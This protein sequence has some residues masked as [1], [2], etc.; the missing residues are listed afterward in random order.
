MEKDWVGGLLLPVGLWLLLSA[1]M[2]S[3]LYHR[4]ASATLIAS[5]I[6]TLAF[7]VFGFALAFGGEELSLSIGAPPE[8]W[9]FAG[10]S[11]F[12]LDGATNLE[13]LR[14]FVRFWPLIATGAMLVARVLGQQ[15]RIVT[16][17]VFTIVVTGIILPL[18][19]CW[20]WGRGW[21]H[22]LGTHVGLG[23][24]TVDLGHLAT[25]GI[26][27]G[28]FGVVW[29]H[30]LPRRESARRESHLPAAH[31][32]VRAVAGAL[33]V[34]VS[35]PAFADAFAPEAP[36]LPMGQFVSSSV[37]ASIAILTAGGYT[38][39][40]MRR[41]DVLSASRAAV[42]AVLATSSGGALLPMPVIAALGIICGLLATIGYY[43]VNERLRWQDDSA[44][45][46][47]VFV[48]AAIGLLATGMFANGTFGVSGMLSHSAGFKADQLL[49]QAVG[50]VAIA[51][52]A[53]GMSKTTLALMRRA[54]IALLIPAE[55]AH[56]HPPKPQPARSSVVV[57]S[58]EFADAAQAISLAYASASEAP[59][60]ASADRPATAKDS[61][62]IEETAP[63]TGEGSARRWLARFR[64]RNEAPPTPKQPR[65]VAYPYRVGG[66]PLSIR[67]PSAS[68]K[69]AEDENSAASLNNRD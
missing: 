41:P 32:P 23:Q 35:V 28:A 42:A 8:R 58:A 21:L 30:S 68:A 17:T 4:L 3:H 12:F 6:A 39:F 54:R 33:L 53:M 48:P 29:L 67:P 55:T 43:A 69:D 2:P 66:R 40:T 59:H 31:L 47:S 38:I 49:A 46:T 7:I 60:L 1:G 16:L 11:G 56:S 51:L 18:V 44:M 25:T 63:A 9:T 5:A 26:A 22:T 10:L 14:A 13:G 61:V 65:K 45:V 64:R 62:A 34:L 19:M 20:M 24:G 36:E 50:L 15:A 57:A 37:A 27:V 52:F